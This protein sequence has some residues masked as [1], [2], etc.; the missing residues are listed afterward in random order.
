VAAA[1]ARA[2]GEPLAFGLATLPLLDGEESSDWVVILVRYLCV[3]VLFL[4]CELDPEFVC[5]VVWQ[6]N[7]L[8]DVYLSFIERK[9]KYY[10]VV[11]FENFFKNPNLTLTTKSLPMGNIRKMQITY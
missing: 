5:L 3:S 11:I 1:C 8:R 9:Y 6:M 4:V 10:E 2:S 7:C